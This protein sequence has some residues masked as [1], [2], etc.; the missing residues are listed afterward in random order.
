MTRVDRAQRF[1]ARRRE[2]ATAHFVP[3]KLGAIDQQHARARPRRRDGR[4]RT[5]WSRA[6]NRDIERDIE[7]AIERTRTRTRIVLRRHALLHHKRQRAGHARSNCAPASPAL[8]ASARASSMV[9][10]ARTLTS[11]S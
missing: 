7:R 1:H 10:A 3:R 9:N 4:A 6:Q 8:C 5:C 11:A 2:A